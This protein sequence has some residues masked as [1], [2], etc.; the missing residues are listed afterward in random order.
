LLFELQNRDIVN[1]ISLI[2]S[3]FVTCPARLNNQGGVV[4]GK[5]EKCNGD[6]CSTR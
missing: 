2:L 5:A 4:D 1:N 3:Y 6:L